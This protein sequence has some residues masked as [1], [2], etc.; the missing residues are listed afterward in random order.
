MSLYATSVLDDGHILL[1]ERPGG[2]QKIRTLDVGHLGKGARSRSYVASRCQSVACWLDVNL[3]L[4]TSEGVWI[5]SSCRGLESGTRDSEAQQK[6]SLQSPFNLAKVQE[7]RECG[8]STFQVYDSF[9][10]KVVLNSGLCHEP[11]L[12][13]CRH[14]FPWQWTLLEILEI[15]FQLLIRAHSDNDAISSPISHL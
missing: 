10:S 1:L 15:G 9:S 6:H 8:V 13:Q 4:W 12:I 2:D 5:I 11:R 3:C 7:C 14:N